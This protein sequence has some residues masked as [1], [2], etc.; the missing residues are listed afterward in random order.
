MIIVESQS[1]DG[2]SGNSDQDSSS[3]S[4]DNSSSVV[5]DGIPD[6]PVQLKVNPVSSTQIDLLWV[7]PEDN[8]AIVGYGIEYRTLDNSSYSTVIDNTENTDTSYSHTGL[9]PNTTYIYRVFAIND[10][11]PSEPSGENLANTLI[12]DPEDDGNENNTQ[13]QESES[14][15][16]QDG[17]SIDDSNTSSLS[18]DTTGAP[19]D[20]TAIPISQNRINLSWS[21]PTDNDDGTSTL[22]G[23]MIESKTSDESDYTVLVTNTGSAST[24]TY[25]HTGLTAGLTYNYRVSAINSLGESSASDMAEA[26]IVVSDQQARPEEQSSLTP[27]S[28]QITLSTDK[29]VYSSDDP[30][31]ISGTISDPTEN[32][33]LGVRVLSSDGTIVYVRS[34][35][36]D[37]DNLFET[38]IAPLQRQSSVWS[39]DAEFTVEVTYNGRTQTTT[40]FETENSGTIT[41]PTTPTQPGTDPTTP[42]QPGTDP[43]TPTQPGTD[44]T[45]PTQPGT[46]PT[47]PTQPG[48]DPTTPTQPGTDPTTPTQPGT[49]PTTPTQPGTDPTTPTQPGTDPTTGVVSNDEFETLKSENTALES[50]NQQLQDEN[51][52]LKIQIDELNKN[53]EQL[54]VVIMEQ[55]RVMMET[56]TP[57]QSGN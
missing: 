42:T 44:P 43:T 3:E 46:D 39:G 18:T 57:L 32:M 19:V 7:A 26:T 41:D 10:I 29:P 24:T 6:P 4:T 16:I 37:N 56:I 2:E 55:V 33:L 48:T 21:A 35:S 31:E 28:L 15:S 25:S 13:Q 36:I 53:I 9:I 8:A 54:N 1:N 52:Q 23:Y 47:T 5:P 12:S 27:Q 22:V 34:V 49:D 38:T 30:I 45:T 20:L 11:G 14:S 50:A 51:N 17:N 40:T